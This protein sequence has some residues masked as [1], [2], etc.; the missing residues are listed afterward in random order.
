[1]RRW[2]VLLHWRPHTPFF[3]GWLVLGVSALGAFVATS[4]AGV[5]LGGIQGF[6]VADTGWSRSS[7]GLAAATGVW[8]S[9]LL[10]PFIGRLAD[11]Y[12]PRELMALGTLLLG[13][14]LFA[15]GYL[16]SLG[17]FF[18]I[19]VLA[20]AISQPVLIGVVPQTLAV[21]FFRRK[22]NLALAMT[23]LFRPISGAIL[24]QI[25]S[26]MTVLYSWRT[27]F[28]WLGIL[29]VL[30]SLPMWFIIRQR[31]EAIG[32]LPD[33]APG[34]AP[35]GPGSS[36]RASRAEATAPG[37]GPASH[38]LPQ[39]HAWSASEALRTRAFWLIALVTLLSVTSSSIIGFNMVPYLHEEAGLSATQATGVL[40][41][42]TLCTLANLLWG[43]LAE[44]WTPRRCL[45]GTLLCAT[46]AVLF[47]A[48]VHSLTS[49]Y[50]FGL[51]WGLVSNAQILIYMLLAHYFGQASY[52]SITGALRPFEAAGLGVG[53]SLG[54]L[55]Y[56]L[57][58]SYRGLLLAVLGTYL[59]T[60]YLMVLAR[61]PAVPSATAA[62]GA[63]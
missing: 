6:I 1:M 32:L 14:G 16:H 39:E 19:A 56:D 24:I 3:Y 62:S 29:S 15:L 30:L 8:A 33:G 42:S 2:D 27:A 31:P 50:V 48:T 13:V 43:Q 38:S 25:I 60:V 49:A 63:S 17:A 35:P 45:I 7:I 46:G 51:L 40:S 55:V 12:G 37:T 53:Q 59:L 11:R 41:M 47:L 26:V 58:G 5:V 23:G 61:P 52:G 9:G 10:A 36:D 21:N 4:I 57:T 20:R 22:R 18:C 28:Q 34:A 54:A 44:R